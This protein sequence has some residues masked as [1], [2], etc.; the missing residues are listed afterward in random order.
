[1]EQVALPR[2]LVAFLLESQAVPSIPI[3]PRSAISA[4]SLFKVSR[5]MLR[6]DLN[7]SSPVVHAR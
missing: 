5:Y 7:V 2:P 1:M 4:P 3:G 6:F